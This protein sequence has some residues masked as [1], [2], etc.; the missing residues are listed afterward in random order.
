MAIVRMLG[1]QMPVEA[2]AQATGV[3]ATTL[4]AFAREFA[5]TP[6]SMVIAGA[7]GADGFEVALAANALNQ[8]HGGVGTT[9]K[10]HEGYLGFDR[11]ASPAGPRGVFV[12]LD[13]RRGPPVMGRG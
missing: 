12:P 11:M 10:P 5:A 1:G 6:P 13:N 7:G 4:D 2:A 9:L 3:S 8:A